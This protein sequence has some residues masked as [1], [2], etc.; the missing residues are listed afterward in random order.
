M[1]QNAREKNVGWR[2]DYFVVNKEM[3]GAVVDSTIQNEV[4]GS[5]HCPIELEIDLTKL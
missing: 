4:I 5:D 1:K 3:I 2:L